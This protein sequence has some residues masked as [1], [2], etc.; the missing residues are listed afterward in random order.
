MVD[1]EKLDLAELAQTNPG[2]DIQLLQRVQALTAPLPAPAQ[3]ARYTLQ[4]PFAERYDDDPPP[5][6]CRNAICR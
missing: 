4:R 6:S 5:V 2:V 3:G 1:D